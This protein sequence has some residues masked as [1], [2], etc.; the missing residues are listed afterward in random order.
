MLLSCF[1]HDFLDMRDMRDHTNPYKQKEEC[2]FGL[3]VLQPDIDWQRFLF[4]I[5]RALFRLGEIA[6]ALIKTVLIETI[7][8]LLCEY[9]P[10]PKSNHSTKQYQSTMSLNTAYNFYLHFLSVRSPF[11]TRGFSPLS[12]VFVLSAPPTSIPGSLE[13]KIREL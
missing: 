9:Q 6:F 4:L 2:K 10:T 3:Q 1:C 5:D 11:Q 13:K 7:V 8:L 12:I